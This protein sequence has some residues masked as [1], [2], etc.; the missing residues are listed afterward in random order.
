MKVVSLD[1]LKAQRAKQGEQL[2]Q[3][4]FRVGGT[5]DDVREV[6]VKSV[7]G[8]MAPVKLEKP[9]GEML[10]SRQARE[11]LS[12][13]VVLDVEM[14]RED[15]PL[16][17]T[18]IYD[19]ISDTSL[20]E[21]LKAKW[22]T[23]GIAVFTR[24]IEGD[25]VKWGALE[26]ESGPTA[27]LGVWTAGISYTREMEEW[28]SMWEMEI[29]NRAFGEAYNALL[30]H[31]HLSPIV[32]FD[33]KKGNVTDAVYIKADGTKGAESDNHAYLS[34]R[35]TL[36]AAKKDTVTDKRPASVLLVNSADLDDIREA[37]GSR[38]I[39]GT[40][41]AATDGFPTVVVYDGYEVT[42]SQVTHKY[43][44]VRP[45]E[46]YY[47]RPK[48]GFKELVKH[49]LMINTY[50]GDVSKLEAAQVIAETWRGVV[51]AVEENVQKIKLPTKK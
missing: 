51:A 8:E 29:I 32:T 42:V 24:H 4:R 19:T 1:T 17:Y 11:E 35:E 21:L 46:A 36:R 37:I 15:V 22:A 10:T 13:K 25:E 38:E 40:S 14:G 45:G 7:N 33:Y 31:L 5:A 43:E 23:R 47:I 34:L 20:P 18:D 44:G 41:Y 27:H 28:N 50:L 49:P 48:K 30:N 2:K 3:V 9:V 16:L 12:A 39:S 26:A 6:E